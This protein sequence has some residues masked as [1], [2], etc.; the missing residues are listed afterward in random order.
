MLL[1]EEPVCPAVISHAGS[2]TSSLEWAAHATGA[3]PWCKYSDVRGNLAGLR[4][5]RPWVPSQRDV[6]VAASATPPELT[7][8]SP[9]NLLKHHEEVK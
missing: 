8:H 7:P 9:K 2:A 4:T 5:W 3:R 6:S 1:L